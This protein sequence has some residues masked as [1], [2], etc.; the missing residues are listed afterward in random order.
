[1]IIVHHSLS[2]ESLASAM[3]SIH[4]ACFRAGVN[5]NSLAFKFEAEVP[6]MEEQVKILT[7][8]MEVDAKRFEALDLK[9]TAWERR[10]SNP[11]FYR[12]FIQSR[13]RR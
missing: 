7:Q 1:M 10:N 8:T 5:P 12:Q 6:S 9:Q 13:R 4:A 3:V 2:P 11:P